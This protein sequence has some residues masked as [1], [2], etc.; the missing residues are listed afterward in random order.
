VSPP[1][2]ALLA[3]AGYVAGLV[4][5]LAGGGSLVSFPAL[6]AVGYPSITANVTNTIAIWPGYVGSAAGYRSELAGQ[7]RRVLVLG[8]TSAAGALTGAIVL[9]NTPERVFRS[10]VPW[11]IAFAAV[12]I[13]V[14]PR[15]AA[16]MQAL[17][18]GSG[19]HR[20]SL[21]HVG[22][23]AGTV[24][25]GYFGAGGGVLLL[26]VLG[27]FLPDGIRALNGLRAALVLVVN[28][29]ALVVFAFF[30]PV[31]WSAVGFMAVAS[32]AGGWTGAS[33]ARRLDSGVLR[34]TIVA[35][36]LVVAAILFVRG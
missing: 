2:A 4:N 6:L 33:V 22:V 9:L 11:L 35:F 14:Q 21:L 20:S 25:G 34:A 17:P 26:G 29:V 1:E 7:G 13:A 19:E 31:E 15:V 16:R 3:G 12:L 28:T 24:Y 10:V 30:G 36:A 32:L 27:L 23:F 8:A 18:G 5:A